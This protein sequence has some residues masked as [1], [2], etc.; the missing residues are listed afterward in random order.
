MCS[1]ELWHWTHLTYWIRCSW[2][3]TCQKYMIILLLPNWHYPTKVKAVKSAG[4]HHLQWFIMVSCESYSLVIY[5]YPLYISFTRSAVERTLA[6]VRKWPSILDIQSN[7]KRHRESNCCRLHYLAWPRT[8]NKMV[9]RSM[10]L[11][12]LVYVVAKILFHKQDNGSWLSGQAGPAGMMLTLLLARYGLG[13]HS[14]LCI[15]KNESGQS[16]GHADAFQPRTLEVLKSLGLADDIINAVCK[17]R[18][19]WTWF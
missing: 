10:R 3:F 1:F 8:S 11:L 18:K 13:N 5:I 9:T 19:N 17:S 2:V 14:L 12:L 7:G 4:G 6:L 16:S 15:D